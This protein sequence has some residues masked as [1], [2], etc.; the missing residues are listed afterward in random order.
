M[1]T[2][3]ILTDMLLVETEKTATVHAPAERVDI[4]DWLQLES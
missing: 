4:A 1:T 2:T 3:D